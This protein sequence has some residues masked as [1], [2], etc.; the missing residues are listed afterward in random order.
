MKRILVIEDNE[1]NLKLM[2]DVLEFS[3]YEIETAVDGLS[4]VD[5]LKEGDFD[6]VLL[7]IQ[8]PVY[9]G[10]DF[11]EE[12]K[13]IKRPPVIAVSACAMDK[14]IEKAKSLGCVDYIPKPI[15]I[16]EFLSTIKNYVS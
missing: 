13:K 4:G 2:K 5:K 7:D 16:D 9:T 11:L 3:G 8:M 1:L 6:L 14:E 10:Y 12:T 15:K